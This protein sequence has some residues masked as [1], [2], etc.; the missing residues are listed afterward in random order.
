[1]T[2]FTSDATAAG[3]LTVTGLSSASQALGV[4]N[5]SAVATTT[6]T[7][8]SGLGGTEDKVTLNLSNLSAVQTIDITDGAA[9]NSI[10]TLTINGTG[11]NTNAAGDTVANVL[12][13]DARAATTIVIGGS[14]FVDIT[15]AAVT[16]AT[17]VNASSNTGGS[18]VLINVAASNST[19]TGGSGN[20][21]VE[22]TAG[23]FDANDIVRLG[24]GTDTL[25]LAV[26]DATA[27]TTKSTGISA[28]EVLR[29]TG[30]LTGVL[31]V[32]NFEATAGDVTQVRLDGGIAAGTV[33]GLT[34]GDTLRLGA[35]GT[36]GTVTV[37]GATTAGTN[38]T[39]NITLSAATD[40][41]AVLFGTGAGLTIAGV[42]NL[43]ISSSRTAAPVA[44]DINTLPFTAAA[45]R[46]ITVSG[47]TNTNLGTVGANV[48]SI[49][50][51]ISTANVAT[52]GLT[53][54]LA[55]GAGSSAQVT[56]G[57]G[58][59]VIVSVAGGDAISTGAGDDTITMGA[60]DDNIN[61][62]AGNDTVIIVDG[63]LTDT[64]VAAFGDGSADTLSINASTTIGD[65][66]FTSVTGL[67]VMSGG[68]GATGAIA[69]NLGTR[70]A[71]AFTS[72]AVRVDQGAVAGQSF[73]IS[74]TGMTSGTLEF[75]GAAATG[76]TADTIVGGA[77]ADRIAGGINTAALGDILTGGAGADI[78][79]WRTR[80]EAI[81]ASL[82]GGGLI[83]TEMDRITDFVAGTDKI[84]LNTSANGFGAALT[85]ASTA[86]TTVAAGANTADRATLTALAT[87]TETLFTGV[88]STA[89]AVRAYVLTTGA[90]I[91]T[92]TGLANKTFL[93]INDDTAAIAATDTWIDITGLVGT[94]SSSDFVFG[95]LFA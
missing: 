17:S 45:A 40:G 44:A 70:V 14:G 9:A 16:G 63:S 81:D 68:T 66:A 88:A 75:R 86:T 1:V 19:I 23:T 21:T 76:A 72:Q 61:G 41:A 31:T 20:D 42:E 52:A 26:A 49:T 50:S 12:V 53:V 94:M 46:T 3:G 90:E 92:A 74:A 7:Y 71:S 51:T 2:S 54:T 80:A 56:T 79:F 32:G 89:T 8:S 15:G 28:V 77:G 10:E 83:A 60:G 35:A 64:D 57:A 59:D 6:F 34:S 87:A 73:N 55:N 95:S 37:T 78:F 18:S 11:S 47:N 22:F 91:T 69:L 33:T 67:E 13:N 48:N 30:A 82:T 29:L 62:G 27:L 58:N 24:G 43:N 93:I 39:V 36:T 4:A 85:F 5:A 65:A 25:R 38:D 84:Q